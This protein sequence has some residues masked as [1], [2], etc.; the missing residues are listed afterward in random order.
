MS[1]SQNTK[2]GYKR[3]SEEGNKGSDM[4]INFSSLYRVHGWG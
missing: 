4:E 3:V 2:H 1:V